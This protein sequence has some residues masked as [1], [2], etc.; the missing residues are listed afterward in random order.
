MNELCRGNWNKSAYM[1]L[2]ST[3]EMEWIC[4]YGRRRTRD[5]R[6]IWH[7]GLGLLI[8][9]HH[10]PKSVDQGHCGSGYV[11]V[12]ICHMISQDQ[13]IKGSCDFG[14]EPPRVIHQLAKFGGHRHPRARW[15]R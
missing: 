8:E 11:M 3:E 12:L 2:N 9:C 13:V 14:K 5:S 10:P 15:Y 1:K 6:F 7:Y 4:I